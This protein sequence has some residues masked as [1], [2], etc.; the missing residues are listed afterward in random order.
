[1]ACPFVRWCRAILAPG[2]VIGHPGRQGA[3]AGFTQR[4]PAPSGGR[5]GGRSRRYGVRRS[6]GEQVAL[7][8][9]VLEDIRAAEVPHHLDRILACSSRGARPRSSF[10]AGSGRRS[11]APTAPRRSASPR[12]RTPPAR[13]PRRCCSPPASRAWSPSGSCSPRLGRA[14]PLGKG[15]LAALAVA[16]VLLS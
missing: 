1:M 8:G 14:A 12:R 10:S 11:G 5:F 13:L 2:A 3:T 4:D 16:S 7:K 15:V 6:D 9:L